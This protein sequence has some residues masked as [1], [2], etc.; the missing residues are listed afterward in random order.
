VDDDPHSG[1]PSTSQIDEN[2]TRVRDLLNSDRRMSDR[3]LADTLNKM[4]RR[5]IKRFAEL[6]DHSKRRH[7]RH[8]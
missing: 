5:P 7:V 8:L 4:N 6:S 2:V 1:W 3:L